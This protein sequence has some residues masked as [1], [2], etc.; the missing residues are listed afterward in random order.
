[1]ALCACWSGQNALN[2]VFALSSSFIMLHVLAFLVDCMLHAGS[3][4]GLKHK[5]LRKLLLC[6]SMLQKFQLIGPKGI[7]AVHAR[8]VKMGS[9]ALDVVFAS[10]CVAEQNE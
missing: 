10:S 7:M 9:D 3:F 1:M 5:F 4:E 6:Q 8:V 2:V